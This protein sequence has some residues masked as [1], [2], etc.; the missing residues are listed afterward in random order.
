MGCQK[1]DGQLF[2]AVL[3]NIRAILLFNKSLKGDRPPLFRGT[4]EEA[5][6]GTDP[7]E[8]RRGLQRYRAERPLESFCV[9]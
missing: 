1:L 4:I 2:A 3:A 9:S 8:V 7:H 5:T 6:L